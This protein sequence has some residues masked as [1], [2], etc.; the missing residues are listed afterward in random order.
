MGN[1]TQLQ[2]ALARP[3]YQL[4]QVSVLT[5]CLK[6]AICNTAGVTSGWE[7]FETNVHLSSFNIPVVPAS[8]AA[9]EFNKIDSRTC[10]SPEF[11]CSNS[12]VQA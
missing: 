6:K 10:Q 9:M 8:L 12:R 1:A 11:S 5:L 3:C 4:A 7:V 2:L